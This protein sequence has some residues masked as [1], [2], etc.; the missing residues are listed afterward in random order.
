MAIVRT[1][2][3]RIVLAVVLGIGTYGC[4]GKNVAPELVAAEDAVHDALA[5]AHDRVEAICKPGQLVE[6][7]KT[8]NATIAQVLRAG[9]QFSLTVQ[10][11]RIGG[12]SVLVEDIGRALAVI[13]E[14]PQSDTR[15][16][17]LADLRRA[18]ES[19]FKGVQ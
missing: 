6:T 13:R 11:E 8:L 18:L 10:S 1:P 9:R 14:L 15:E 19:A 16:R 2:V 17:L 12:L 4:A 7:C 3:Q 5:S